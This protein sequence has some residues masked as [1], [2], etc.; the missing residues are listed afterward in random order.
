MYF[1]Q[2]KEKI[3]ASSIMIQYIHKA[4]R[5]ALGKGLHI[6]CFLKYS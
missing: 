4:A 1:L 6:F 2:Q 3:K 5:H